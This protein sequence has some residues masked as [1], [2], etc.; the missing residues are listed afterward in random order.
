VVAGPAILRE[1][2]AVERQD[3][4]RHVAYA[5]ELGRRG[6]QLRHAAAQEVYMRALLLLVA[7]GYRPR[8]V[9]T[10]ASLSR[11]ERRSFVSFGRLICSHIATRLWLL[12]NQS[13][14]RRDI[15]AARGELARISVGWAPVCTR[16]RRRCAV[17][18]K[19]HRTLIP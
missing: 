15:R 2:P 19:P 18:Q 17:Y 6:G 14:R 16:R 9:P 12:L 10:S 7:T 5:I 4:E 1:Q 11:M 3:P 13:Q 8:L